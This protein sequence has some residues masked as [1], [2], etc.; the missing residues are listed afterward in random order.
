MIFY[1]S[2]KPDY[3]YPDCFRPVAFEVYENGKCIGEIKVRLYKYTNTDNMVHDAQA[4]NK[5]IG[6]A[7]ETLASETRFK[8]D[9]VKEIGRT[10]IVAY[11]ERFF[12]YP[13]YR[14]HGYGERCL[15]ELSANIKAVTLTEPCAF[16]TFI[17][18]D[19]AYTRNG[20]TILLTHKEV[21]QTKKCMRHIFQKAGFVFPSNKHPF[22]GYLC[23]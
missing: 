19:E 9:W 11:I 12:I 20:E 16:I 10:P 14:G 5:Y 4:A 23:N 21:K 3:L 2:V 6:A 1:T 8:A 15:S 18:P 7:T 22:C 13:E 17:E